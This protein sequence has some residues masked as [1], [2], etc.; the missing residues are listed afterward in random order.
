MKK[1]SATLELFGENIEVNALQKNDS[2]VEIHSNAQTLGVMPSIAKIYL[3]EDYINFDEENIKHFIS[4]IHIEK[5]KFF[6]Y[7]FMVTSPM[8]TII[9]FC[10]GIF[11]GIASYMSSFWILGIFS[12]VFSLFLLIV[13][14]ASFAFAATIAL[15]SSPLWL[16]AMIAGYEFK[17]RNKHAVSK[18][19]DCCQKIGR[20]IVSDLPKLEV[21]EIK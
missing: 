18:L 8:I 10:I 3:Y 9:R 19:K 21:V 12:L 6:K 5:S 17:R 16:S 1:F 15:Y 14:V 20:E 7:F 11:A 13:V 2:E 4:T